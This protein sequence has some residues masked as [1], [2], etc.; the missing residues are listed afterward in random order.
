MRNRPFYLMFRLLLIIRTLFILM[1]V[2]MIA[3]SLGVFASM[4]ITFFGTLGVFKVLG[5]SIALTDQAIILLILTSGLIRG[6]LRYLEHLSGHE[7]AFRLLAR[8]RSQLFL[9]LRA[10]APAKTEGKKKGTIVSMMSS[11]IETLEV[12]YAH[13]IAPVVIAITVGIVMV[14]VISS[15]ASIGLGLIALVSYLVIGFGLPVLFSLQVRTLT[16]AYR[17]RF[18]SY[19]DVF[20]ETLWGLNDSLMTRTTNARKVL[21][22]HE[23][24]QMESLF[25][26]LKQRLAFQ[27]GL[28]DVSLFLSV[29][30]MLMVSGASYLA[31]WPDS[32]LFHAIDLT[33]LVI[34]VIG[35]FSS[36]GPM[37]QLAALPSS[38]NQTIASANRLINVMDEHP[39]VDEVTNGHHL[40]DHRVTIRD[41]NY[42]YEGEPLISHLNLE[43]G[44]TGI[45]GIYGRSGVG[46]STLLKLIMR[47]YDTKEG[48]ILIDGYP[49]KT[50]NSASLRDTIGYVMQDTYVFSDTLA[51]NM[52]FHKHPDPKVIREVLRQTGLDPLIDVLNDGLETDLGSQNRAISTGERQRIGLSRVLI[53]HTKLIL[54]DEPTSNVDIINESIILETLKVISKKAM[55]VLVTHKL[56][57][58]SICDVV[59]EMK[60]GKLHKVTSDLKP[61]TI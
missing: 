43:L 54:L 25:F 53:N 45:I 37:V 40:L 61:N 2:T 24:D 13:T 14:L 15:V 21:F 11:D 57:T 1:L 59:Y 32:G 56:S 33:G 20:L 42:G 10:L 7:L 47:F 41:L 19:N 58:L 16:D 44:E 26:K 29:V 49:L 34:S 12:F 23:S 17:A 3:G 39:A 60:D 28:T 50:I 55:V 35:M 4:S 22:E 9:K 48:V 31:L 38:L 52:A 6:L 46:K 36:F 27:K 51:Y 8:L 5:A 30:L 18:S